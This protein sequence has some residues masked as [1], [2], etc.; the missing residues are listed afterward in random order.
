MFVGLFLATIVLLM[1]FCVPCCICFLIPLLWPNSKLSLKVREQKEKIARLR[2]TTKP[3]GPEEV[4]LDSGT[5]RQLT[6][7]AKKDRTK[8]Y[9]LTDFESGNERVVPQTE[10]E[11]VRIKANVRSVQ[12]R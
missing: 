10:D 2:K 11:S 7:E 8:V 9:P 3:G 6:I 12:K 4:R 5:Q 1:C